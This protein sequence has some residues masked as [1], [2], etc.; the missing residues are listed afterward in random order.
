MAAIIRYF[1]PTIGINAPAPNAIV[2]GSFTVS[3]IAKCDLLEDRAD[4]QGLV[5]RHANEAMRN[6]SVSL[7]T[8]AVA[9]ATPT[10]P[11]ATPW[12]SWRFDVNG[13]PNGPLTI[14]ATVDAAGTGGQPGSADTSQSV[15]VD[16]SPPTLTINPPPDGVPPAPPYIATITGTAADSPAAVAGV[17]WQF[18]GGP[19]QAATGTTNWSAQVPLPGL[20]LHTVAF[21]ARDNA[22]N[23]SAPT[24]TQVRVGDMTPPALS[25]T[26]PQAGE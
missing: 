17:E 18:G 7:G 3:G 15:T 5:V 6:I 1:S 8:G 20:G 19:W 21:R 9:S 22:G 11:P 24:S 12:T 16:V 26:A 14:T 10:G 2:S 23:V 25:I 13:R 4:E